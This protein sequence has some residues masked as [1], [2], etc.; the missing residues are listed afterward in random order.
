MAQACRRIGHEGGVSVKTDRVRRALL[1]LAL[2]GSAG[3]PAQDYPARAVRVVV[4]FPPGGGTDIIAR[5]LTQK[6]AERLNV[7][8]LIDNRPGAGGSI[9]AEVVAKAPPDGY[10]IGVVSSSHAINP[11]LYRKLSYDAAR[12]FAAITLIVSVPG[13]LVVHP[14]VPVRSVKELIAL[15]RS[16]PGQIYYG[17]AGN[18]TPPHLAAELFKSMTGISMVHVPYKGNTQA[19]V[20]LVSGQLSVSFPTIVSALP[21]VR[22]G[23]LRGLAVTSAKRAAVVPELP[24][25]AEAGVP[26]YDSATWF[27]MLAPAG[28]PAAIVAKLNQETTRAIQLPDTRSRFLEQGL[29]PVGNKPEEFAAIINADMTKWAKVVAASG[30]KI[31]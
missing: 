4:P 30:M 8:F 6:I 19:Y 7:N 27:G 16:R 11:S 20:D 23:R 12:D 26:G 14:S 31:D 17:S 13:V 5:M 18:G 3:A 1:V 24:S 15:A 22:A 29:E 25:I 28:T 2:A 9:G 10:T 21:F